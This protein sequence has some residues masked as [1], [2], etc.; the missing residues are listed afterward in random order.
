MLVYMAVDPAA[1]IVRSRS[2]PQKAEYPHICAAIVQE[3]LDQGDHISNANQML[4]FISERLRADKPHPLADSY[5][6]AIHPMNHDRARVSVFNEYTEP[7]G[8]GRQQ[9]HDEL[10]RKNKENALSI[11]HIVTDKGNETKGEEDRSHTLS[12]TG[13]YLADDKSW[14]TMGH[15]YD[16]IW[17]DDKTKNQDEHENLENAER[18]W[19]EISQA[20][21]RAVSGPTDERKQA[22]LET[23]WWLSHDVP[24]YNGSDTTARIALEYLSHRI[25]FTIPFVKERK[26][27]SRYAQL[28]PLDDFLEGWE[29]GDYFDPA[30][31]SETILQWQQ[32]YLAGANRHSGK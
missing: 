19:S 5:Y 27:L 25:G 9:I 28:R 15:P 21:Y 10:V 24:M 17:T 13:V 14:A 32:D 2:Y 29:R 26:S 20:F 3:L 18:R 16:H 12:L 6:G 31:R 22:A 23:F 8:D 30:A 11:E 4:N 7:G 1:F